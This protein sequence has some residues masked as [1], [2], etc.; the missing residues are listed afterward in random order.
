MPLCSPRSHRGSLLSERSEAGAH[1][2][3]PQTTLQGSPQTAAFYFPNLIPF[4]LVTPVKTAKLAP[5]PCVPPP[6]HLGN[7]VQ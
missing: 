5:L 3:L 4:F 2:S 6:S 7:G 1:T